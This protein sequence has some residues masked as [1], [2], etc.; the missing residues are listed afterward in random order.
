MMNELIKVII[1]ERQQP[2]VS[3]REL[4]QFLGVE[5][6]YKDWFPRMAE[7][8]F[9]EGT[10]FCSN[11]SESTGGRPATDHALTLDMAKELCMIQRTER[12]KQA[13]QYFIQ[14]EKDFN[15]PEKIM[16]RALLIA[17]E[18]IK[19]LNSQLAIAAPKADFY[20]AVTASDDW[21][22]MDK[23]AKV[24]NLGY[25]RNTMFAKLRG[26]GIL[27]GDNYP[28]QRYVDRGHFRLIEQQGWKDRDG[29]WHPTFKTLV[30]VCT[31]I[32][33]IRRTLTKPLAAAN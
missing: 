19:S 11:L 4:H 18:Q 33:F 8:G 30:S 17:D 12:G 26:L 10:D 14:V 2:T 1:N 29:N 23:V 13:R 3:G 9:T 6:Q 28:Y 20:D 16:A 15:S 27:D 21:I 31:G 24:L 32:D 22:S 7:Y 25:G 5:T